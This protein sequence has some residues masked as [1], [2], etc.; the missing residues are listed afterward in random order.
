TNVDPE[1]ARKLAALGYLSAT[2]SAGGGPLPDPKDR[3]GEIADMARASELAR[4]GQHDAAASLLRSLLA[5]NPKFADAWNQLALTLEASGRE[6]EAAD[7]YREAIRQSPSLSGE[8][9]LS[10]GSLLLALG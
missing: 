8:F 3:I 9:A 2:P 1:E 10:L 6:R 7:A 5:R 4:V